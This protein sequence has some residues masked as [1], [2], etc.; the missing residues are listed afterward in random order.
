MNTLMQLWIPILATAV[1]IFIASSLIHMVFK[2]HNSDYKKLGNEDVVRAALRG[3]PPGQ[4]SMPHCVGMKEMQSEEM[5]AKFI[6]GPI[7]MVTV[8]KNGMVNMGA[9]LLQWFL[10][11]LVIAALAGCLAREAYAAT[12]DAQA[13]GYLV[14]MVS[15]LAYSAG[16]VTLGI[17]M[18]KPWGAVL[19]DL[20]DGLIYGVISACTF[21]W[22]WP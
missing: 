13:A 18:A 7:A 2:W 11:S 16:S 19:K 15:F 1:F 5:K 22:L 17:W 21:M 14:G 3:T 9:T 10:L 6:E 8:R 4:Y 12:S 20:L